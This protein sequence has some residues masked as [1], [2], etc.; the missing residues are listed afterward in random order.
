[1]NNLKFTVF[2]TQSKDG[3]NLHGHYMLPLNK[4]VAILYFVH[5]LGGHSGRFFHPAALFA[6]N[7]IASIGIDLRG[8][9]LSE[10]KR[11]HAKN[12]QN[13]VEDLDACVLYGNKLFENNLPKVIMGNS[14][15]GA[16]ALLY[17]NINK[18][19]FR[20]IILT[21]PW[22]RLTQP[23]NTFKLSVLNI[24]SKIYPK[25]TLSSKVKAAS[26]TNQT[27]KKSPEETDELIHKQ[28]T[29]KLLITI[30]KVG[31]SILDQHNFC[32]LPTLI[33]HS[34]NDPVTSYKASQ[35]FYNKYSFA[36]KLVTLDLYTHEIPFEEENLIFQK[37]IN[38]INKITVTHEQF[39]D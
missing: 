36:C 14:M 16:I 3:T 27:E 23:I 37:V 11:G 34:I 38:H 6:K 31:N 9:G 22:F 18:T 15:G 4:P 5:G 21:A 19:L 28:I 20:G 39:Q 10:G 32:C 30:Y 12:L 2:K 8:N 29:T 17:A 33:I 1:M 24:I 35:E 7:N 25:F 26:N 13:Y